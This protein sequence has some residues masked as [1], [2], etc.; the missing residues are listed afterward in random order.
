MQSGQIE[1]RIYN[2][3]KFHAKA[4]ITHPRLEVVG[5]KALVGSSNFTR[6]G[7]TQNIE[8]NIQVQS[9]GE[10]NELQ[11]WYEEH[12]EEAVDISEEIVNLITRHIEEWTPFDVYVRALSEYFRAREAHSGFWEEN[13]S[14]MFPVLDKY[15]KEAYWSMMKIAA[16]HNGA[17][18]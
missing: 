11:E 14:K 13:E 15:Q 18:L 16:Q 1:C 10:V 6:P 8:L 9:P 17:F 5:S 12:W 2:K 3:D 4:Y 7:L